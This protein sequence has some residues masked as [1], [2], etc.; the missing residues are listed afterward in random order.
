MPPNTGGRGGIWHGSFDPIMGNL[1]LT[2]YDSSSSGVYFSDN[3]Y[4]Y[5]KGTNKTI[6]LTLLRICEDDRIFRG[7]CVARDQRLLFVAETSAYGMGGG[8]VNF[9]NIDKILAGEGNETKFLT[10][11]VNA[12]FNPWDCSAREDF[13][14][15]SDHSTNDVSIY[16]LSNLTESGVFA[17]ENRKVIA[18]TGNEF[19]QV[20]NVWGVNF[21]A[22]GNLIGNH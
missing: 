20:D 13:V 17:K 4:G 9:W 14:A 16:G 18:E 8:I 5:L 22:L 19:G 6:P 10:A 3:I 2:I 11:E 21:D 15:I 1:W 7:V 12:P